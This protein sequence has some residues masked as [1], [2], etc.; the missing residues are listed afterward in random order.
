M[1]FSKGAS[2]NWSQTGF[3]ITGALTIALILFAIIRAMR[4]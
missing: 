1:I 3:L 4:N 2:F